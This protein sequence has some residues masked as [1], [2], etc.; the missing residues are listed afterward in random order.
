MRQ[1]HLGIYGLVINEGKILVVRK[2][3]GPYQGL[4][5][6]PGGRPQHGEE[7]CEA[8]QREIKEETGV[9]SNS[10]SLLG[11]LSFLYPYIN[12]EEILCEF[13][14]IALIYRVDNAEFTHFNSSITLE[15]VEGSLWIELNKMSKE[16]ASPL[17]LGALK[18]NEK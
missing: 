6:L 13:Y 11:N 3:R 12:S 1:L 4:L 5:D 15:D 7:L 18:I 10:F 8:L 14:H 2:S 16:N 9:I 17:V